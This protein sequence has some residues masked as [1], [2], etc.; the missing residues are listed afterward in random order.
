[1]TN[2]KQNTSKEGQGGSKKSSL[3][4]SWIALNNDAKKHGWSEDK[5]L[6]FK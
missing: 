6:V 2:Q 5:P 4:A 3:T 1:M